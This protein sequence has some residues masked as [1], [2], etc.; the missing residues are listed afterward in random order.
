MY[1]SVEKSV[2]AFVARQQ[3]NER[4]HQRFWEGFLTV[5]AWGAQWKAH[6]PISVNSYCS[7][8]ESK[9]WVLPTFLSISC[10]SDFLSG[11]T[12][13]LNIGQTWWESAIPYLTGLQKVC[14]KRIQTQKGSNEGLF[15]STRT[16]SMH[17]FREVPFIDKTTLKQQINGQKQ[18]K[19][20]WLKPTIFQTSNKL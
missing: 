9:V 5:C 13:V 12:K 11:T 17:I 19:Q 18:W 15:I 14:R 4:G 2:T 10:F 8:T 7:E 6:I 20:Y 3:K 16:H 1:V